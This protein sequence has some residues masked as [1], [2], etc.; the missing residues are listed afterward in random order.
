MKKK[1][2]A[3][4]AMGLAATAQ[5][6][7][8]IDLSAEASRPAAN[9]MVRASVFSEATGSNPAELAR[10]VNGD[11]A[12]ALKVIRDRK[13]VSVKSG[14]QSTYPVYTQARKID[15]WRMRSELLI[16]SKDFGTVSDLL[17]RLQQMRLAVGDISQ[18]PSPETRHQ[19]EDE[20]MREAI[21][22][23]QNR[24][25]LIADTLGKGW[26]IKQMN[27]NQAGGMPPTP[28][29]RVRAAA[30]MAEAAP[31]PLEAGESV[32]T[33]NVSGQIELAD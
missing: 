27:I 16:E 30:M 14:N 23:F 15:G 4:L 8:L 19:A 25:A 26:K 9:D 21:R 29:P 13:G 11:I 6:G 2:L 32:V 18:M 31:A 24:A 3:L 28:M 33:T 20:A 5:A 12:E 10:R 1:L 7:A 22:A 17:G